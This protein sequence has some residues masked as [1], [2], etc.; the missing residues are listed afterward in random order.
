MKVDNPIALSIVI[1]V[2]NEE[3][4][5][6]SLLHYLQQEAAHKETIE[7][8]VIDGGSTDST[9]QIAETY[10]AIVLHSEKGKAKQMNE[11]AT[12]AKGSILY[13][14]HADTF[15][16]A[17]YDTTI[18]SAVAKDQKAGCFR[19]K[20]NSPSRFLSFFSWFT[21][22]N[23]PLCRGGDQ[24]LFI[25][26]NLFTDLGGFNEAYRIY[27]DNEFIGRLYRQASFTVL[28]QEVLTSAR[29]Y[30]AN[31]AWI[32]QYHFTV[33]HLKKFLGAPPEKLYDYY[34]KNIRSN[35]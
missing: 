18:T 10:G 8:L 2:L 17:H 28:P 3:G 29:K 1:P 30:K 19:L 15:P 5:I 25:T 35:M 31:G 14:L 12:H 16:P 9:M 34:L 21:R 13:F 26:K 33:V 11:G 32:L 24:S 27:E 6:G 7:V 4:T 22:F 20:F 23:V